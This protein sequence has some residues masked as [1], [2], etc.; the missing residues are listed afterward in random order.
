MKYLLLGLLAYV[1]WHWYSA[2][3]Q[4]DQ[5]TAQPPESAPP[6]GSGAERMVSCAECG[7]HLPQSESIDGRGALHFCS[8]EHRLR[9]KLS[10]L[11]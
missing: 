3:R 8:D 4:K 11:S 9:H 1:A 7:I 2:Q 6:A 10:Q 5:P